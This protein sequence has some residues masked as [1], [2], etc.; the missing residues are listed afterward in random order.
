MCILLGF[1]GVL[2][3]IDLKTGK[4]PLEI[5]YAGCAAGML[6]FLIV[7]PFSPL[8]LVQGAAV[9][10][11]VLLLSVLSGGGIG[12]GDGLV[13]CMTGVFLGGGRNLSLLVLSSFLALL[14]CVGLV[15]TKKAGSCDGIPF[16]PLILTADVLLLFFSGPTG[17]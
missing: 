14:V 8:C 13:F 5:F 1:L 9:G 12:L 11:A 2:A 6:R 17:C 3:Y 15:L 10:G 16:V 4:V 7:A